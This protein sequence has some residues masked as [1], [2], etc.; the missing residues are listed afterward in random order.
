M[1][2]I[3]NQTSYD[4]MAIPSQ[5]IYCTLNQQK[6]Q[7]KNYVTSQCALQLWGNG[8]RVKVFEAI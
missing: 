1:Y 4:L 2:C 5:S 7:L 3:H 6:Q 8:E